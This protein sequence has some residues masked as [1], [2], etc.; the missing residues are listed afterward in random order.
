LTCPSSDLKESFH[1]RFAFNGVFR[2][3]RA[4][5]PAATRLYDGRLVVIEG[6]PAMTTTN[7]FDH[8][9]LERAVRRLNLEPS[10]TSARWGIIEDPPMA[11]AAEG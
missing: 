5:P 7:P 8:V 4:D 10:V 2:N 6:L 3:R 9:G 1:V 11:L